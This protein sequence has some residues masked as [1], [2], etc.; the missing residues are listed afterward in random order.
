MS[1]ANKT[2]AGVTLAACLLTTLARADCC[3]A[4]WNP[5]SYTNGYTYNLSHWWTT[6]TNF[7]FAPLTETIAVTNTSATS[8]RVCDLI[9]GFTYIFAVSAVNSLGQ[10][11]VTSPLL[12]YY[13]T[14]SSTIHLTIGGMG[15]LTFM[16]GKRVSTVI[17]LPQVFGPPAGSG[18]NFVYDFGNS[19]GAIPYQIQNTN[20]DA[21]VIAFPTFSNVGNVV[22]VIRVPFGGGS[23]NVTV[24]S[25]APFTLAG[26]TTTN[27]GL[28][29]P[30]PWGSSAGVFHSISAGTWSYQNGSGQA[31]VGPMR[32]DAAVTRGA[33][34]S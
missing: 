5:G 28:Y 18:T 7:P 16:G 2:V 21:V 32:V 6:P 19:R 27:L 31:V 33:Y 15:R 9:P 4:S 10:E 8:A 30:S 22:W 26:N 24:D 11:V 1:R 3:T 29:D 13:G 17:G 14:N 12:A 34:G 25:L 23:Y 20:N